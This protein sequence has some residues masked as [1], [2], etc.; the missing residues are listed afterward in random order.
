MQDYIEIKD[1][2]DQKSPMLAHLCSGET[3]PEI[4][5]SGPELL[6]KFKTSPFGNPFH[7]LPL[8]YLPGFELE[9]QVDISYMSIFCFCMRFFFRYFTL[10]SNRQLI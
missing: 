5:S 9:V 3:V 8:S 2:W 6:V 10:I 4:I 7:P 1:G